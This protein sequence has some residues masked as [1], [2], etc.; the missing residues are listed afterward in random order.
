MY[1][2]SETVPGTKNEVVRLETYSVVSYSV[3]KSYKWRTVNFKCY[4]GILSHSRV[5]WSTGLE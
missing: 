2:I 1:T 3:I 5:Y 4:E